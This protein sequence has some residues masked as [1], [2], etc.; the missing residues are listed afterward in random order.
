M[1]T[2]DEYVAEMKKRIDNWSA[3]ID[4][5]QARGHEI[6]EDVRAKYEEQ[7]VALRAK[8]EQGEKKLE[9]MH[10][11]AENNWEH[12]KMDCDRVWDAFKDSFD[13]FK[14]HFK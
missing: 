4:A 3:E 12:L 7:L 11:A 13:T 10:A 6:K 14:S 2:K 5:M 1:L 8:R 9:E